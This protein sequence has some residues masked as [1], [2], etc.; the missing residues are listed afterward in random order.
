MEL[1]PKLQAAADMCDASEEVNLDEMAFLLRYAVDE[2]AE[3]P[4]M[5]TE[6]SAMMNRFRQQLLARCDLLHRPQND[7]NVA[8]NGT[9]QELE[10]LDQSLEHE[11]KNRYNA[12]ESTPKEKSLSDHTTHQFM[13]GR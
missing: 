10:A 12:P 3:Q 1:V 7:R 6:H 13:S 11:M 2:L 4:A 8:S 9:F 5:K